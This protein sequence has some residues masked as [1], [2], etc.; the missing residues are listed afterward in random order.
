M[1]VASLVQAS[2]LLHLQGLIL[3]LVP[4]IT[5]ALS[6]LLFSLFEVSRT[7]GVRG[8]F[9][10]CSG[11]GDPGASRNIT[12]VI[13]A[14]CN[15]TLFLCLPGLAIFVSGLPIGTT[16]LGVKSIMVLAILSASGGEAPLVTDSFSS[17]FITSVASFRAWSSCS[18]DSMKSLS[19]LG[20]VLS[21]FSSPLTETKSGTSSSVSY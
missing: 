14:L 5:G 17:I 16:L 15:S 8:T 13:S 11:S 10:V 6:S 18:V 1:E 3:F 9:A 12:S 21:R 19:L 7:L 20:G 4:L 2:G